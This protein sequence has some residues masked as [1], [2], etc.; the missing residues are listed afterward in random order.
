ME[1]Q[2]LTCVWK[3]KP[4][5]VRMNF[6]SQDINFL[7]A[8]RRPHWLSL[9]TLWVP[10]G[11]ETRTRTSPI[12]HSSLVTGMIPCASGPRFGHKTWW[13]IS[14]GLR[15]VWCESRIHEWAS[16]HS[17]WFR[18]GSEPE[19]GW[20]HH[21]QSGLTLGPKVLSMRV[22]GLCVNMSHTGA[23]LSRFH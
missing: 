2:Y 22:S 12:H 18:F 20:G 16:P 11:L 4:L 1:K 19:S 10:S 8:C 23:K 21:V 9:W 17:L 13:K 15:S 5:K 14:P 6:N 3:K 7:T